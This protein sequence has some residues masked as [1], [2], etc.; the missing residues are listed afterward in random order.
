MIPK[1]LPSV[2]SGLR[3]RDKGLV[4]IVLA[5]YDPGWPEIFDGE[6][7][8]ILAALGDLVVRVDHIGSTSVPGLAAKPVL[9]IQMEVPDVDA[10][11]KAGGV[12]KMERLG[13]Q[14]RAEYLSL[15]PFRHLFTRRDEPVI[16]VNIHTVADGHPWAARHRLF[17]DYLRSNAMARGRYLA[18]KQQLAGREWPSVNDYAGAKSE[19]VIALEEEAMEVARLPLEERELLRTSRF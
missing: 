15:L 7:S 19:V 12:V 14:H 3:A 11:V 9:D 2:L 6:K 1:G 4:R 8:R 16:D 17:R 13:F 18:V 10:F 5:E